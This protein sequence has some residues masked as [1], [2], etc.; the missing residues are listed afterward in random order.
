MSSFRTHFQ[1]KWISLNYKS[2]VS[3]FCIQFLKKIPG[4][5]NFSEQYKKQ[6]PQV[7]SHVLFVWFLK[8]D[9]AMM[10]KS[11]VVN[12]GSRKQTPVNLLEI[13]L[14]IN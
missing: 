13:T 14:K 3:R 7:F 10:R 5:F 6:K 11:E 12:F 1:E 8:N 4:Y 2:K 9:E